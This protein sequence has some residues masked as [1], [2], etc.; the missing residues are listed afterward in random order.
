MKNKF[1]LIILISHISLITKIMAQNVGINTVSPNSSAIL[2]IS[3]SSFG[4]LPPQIVTASLPTAT[5]TPQGLL[6]YN[7][8]NNLFYFNKSLNVTPSWGTLVNA[9]N[10]LTSSGNT[11]VSTVN[12]VAATPNP[13]IINTVSNT[14]SANALYTTINGS[15]GSSVNII[16][17][18]VLSLNT[19]NL[20]STVNGVAN[21]PALDLTPAITAVTWT[22]G[23][24]NNT[25]TTSFLGTTTK[26]DLIF[27][28]F[29]TAAV[30]GMRLSSLS[31]TPGYVGIGT[32][33][34]LSTLEVNGVYGTTISKVTAA[35][36]LDNTA[37]VWYC[38]I[39][40][41]AYAVTLPS[42]VTFK[43]RRYII[44]NSFGKAKNISVNYN[45]TT[46]F[47][48]TE[49]TSIEIIA[50]GTTWIQIYP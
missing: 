50:D 17:S 46:L 10:T 15:A 11:L 22:L 18:N 12:G 9:T 6:F 35:T 23:G 32:P 34:P 44:L 1:I 16:N 29:T 49:G 43:N 8:T 33:N 7:T 24:N 41:A 27:K 4:L 39:G 19:T 30:E 36:N 42:A 28:V 2:D 38:S 47:T 31:A 21:T 26:Q 13:T 40:N 45:G 25:T 14:S 37:T 3:S 48:I 5:T 20:T